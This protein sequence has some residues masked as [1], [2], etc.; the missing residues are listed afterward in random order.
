[1]ALEGALLTAQSTITAVGFKIIGAILLWIVGRWLISM[2][3]KLI[4]RGLTAKQFDP[5]LQRYLVSITGVAL[6]VILVIGILGYFG[7]ETT[8]FA[9]LI[10]AVGIAIGAAWSGLLANFAAGAFLMILRPFKVG[11]YIVGGGVEGTVKEIGLFSSTLLTP[12]NVITLVGNNKI[13]GDTLKNFTASNYRRVDRVAQIDHSVDP[14]DAIARLK[15]RIA[16]IPNVTTAPPP[17]VEILDFNALGIQLAVRPYCKNTDYWQV[18][19]DTNR[20]IY[21]EFSKAG[22]AVPSRHETQKT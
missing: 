22:Y 9:A 1:M 3:T 14:I 7:I 2:V 11:D 4:E 8:S 16:T 15:A 13:L 12:D 10:A 5:T 19:F 6:T 17:D 18:Y 20:V 21:E